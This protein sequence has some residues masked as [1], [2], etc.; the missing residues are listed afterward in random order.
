[1]SES[2]KI[3]RGAGEKKLKRKQL[4]TRIDRNRENIGRPIKSEP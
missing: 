4:G 3:A 2:L 1:M